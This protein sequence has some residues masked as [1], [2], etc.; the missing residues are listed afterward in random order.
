MKNKNQNINQFLKLSQTVF[1]FALVL[2]FSGLSA[3]A[4]KPQ[5]SPSPSKQTEKQSKSKSDSAKNS[6]TTAPKK[7]N[8]LEFTDTDKMFQILEGKWLYM[9]TDC[10]KAFTINVSAD[11]K[12]IKLIYPKPEGEEKNEYIYNVSEVGSYYIRGQYEGEKRLTN[13]GKPQVWDFIFLSN[14]EFIWHRSD[15]KDLAA[16]EPITRCKEIYLA[17]NA[18]IDKIIQAKAKQIQKFEEAIKP[19][20]QKAKESYPQ[21]KKRYLEGLPAKE[22]LFITTRLR[23]KDGRFEQVFIA[24]KEIKDGVV[25]GLIWSDVQFISGH[26]HGDNYSFPESELIDWTI[27]KADGSEEG[28][29]VGNFLETYQPQ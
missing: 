29:F 3:Q 6:E 9:T 16:T 2:S 20:I 14:D 23:D 8:I 25:K 24:V 5:S 28:N 7:K 17:P 21:A 18:P 12:T 27:S 15:W 19:Y 11:R 26:K 1:L 22:T 4:Q 10:Q 13:D